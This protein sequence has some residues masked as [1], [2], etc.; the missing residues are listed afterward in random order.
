MANE[1]L[2]NFIDVARD[3]LQEIDK[4]RSD[5]LLKNEDTEQ[6]IWNAISAV[7][8]ISQAANIIPDA[9]HL[10]IWISNGD[11]SLSIA[12]DDTEHKLYDTKTFTTEIGRVRASESCY[13]YDEI[14]QNVRDLIDSAYP[15]NDNGECDEI[16]LTCEVSRGDHTLNI[17]AAR[18][19]DGSTDVTIS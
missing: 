8:D 18:F 19:E 14:S 1:T 15:A 17:K 13:N 11:Q 16:C 4:A 10:F 6:A 3:E 5:E 9:K 7:G 2:F 12:S